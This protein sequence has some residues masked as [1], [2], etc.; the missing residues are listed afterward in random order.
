[1]H[2]VS[3][4]GARP[5]SMHVH[6]N[7]QVIYMLHV[8]YKQLFVVAIVTVQYSCC[9]NVHVAQYKLIYIHNVHSVASCLIFIIANVSSL[10]RANL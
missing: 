8:Q 2:I 5:K 9:Q 10:A 3:V 4:K 7:M 1:M 6:Y